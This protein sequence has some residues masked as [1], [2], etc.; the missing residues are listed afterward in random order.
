MVC[1]VRKDD[2]YGWKPLSCG[3]GG[4]EGTASPSGSQGFRIGRYVPPSVSNV[5]HQ[6]GFP[7]AVVG[8]VGTEGAGTLVLRKTA[9]NHMPLRVPRG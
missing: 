8:I 2:G 3:R 9:T 4:P 1:G 6:Q 5:T 7:I